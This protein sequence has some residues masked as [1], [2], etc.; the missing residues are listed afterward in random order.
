MTSLWGC[1]PPTIRVF[2]VHWA[3]PQLVRNEIL[4]GFA[5]WYNTVCLG[6]LVA[7]LPE[8]RHLLCLPT[9]LS[10]GPR[11]ASRTIDIQNINQITQNHGTLS[12]IHPDDSVYVS[13]MYLFVH[14]TNICWVSVS[15]QA[16]FGM[17]GNNSPYSSSPETH[18][19]NRGRDSYQKRNWNNVWEGNMSVGS[20][21]GENMEGQGWDHWNRAL[22][23][24]P[25]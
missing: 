3:S 12:K 20:N 15:C 25:Q 24:R 13:T 11:T 14:T 17:V 9:C 6:P 10:P 16:L 2:P 21:L 4:L 1:P 23:G 22:L 18:F 5:R 8:G 7:K 19:G